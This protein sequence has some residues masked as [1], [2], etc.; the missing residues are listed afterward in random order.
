MA[1]GKKVD[2]IAL[3]KQLDDATR[4]LESSREK[5]PSCDRAASKLRATRP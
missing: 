3:A 2:T 5:M 1:G 4:L